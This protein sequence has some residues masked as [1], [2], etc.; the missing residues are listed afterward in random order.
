MEEIVL[1]T[2]GNGSKLDHYSVVA[3]M[4]AAVSQDHAQLRLLIYE[5][6][7]TRLRK[8]LYKQF[9][10]L[11]WSGI[12]AQVLALEA[13]I[14]Q[15]EADCENNLL[16]P[17]LVP[18]VLSDERHSIHSALVPR[19]DLRPTLLFAD[20]DHRDPPRFLTS[21][22]YSV[23]P[24]LSLSNETELSDRSVM[25]RR[26]QKS[27]WTFS[28]II[29]LVVAVVLGVAIYGVL[30]SRFPLGLWGFD[31]SV[32]KSEANATHQGASVGG[33][34]ATASSADASHLASPGIPIPSAYGVYAVSNKQLTELDL[35]PIKVPDQR[36]AISTLI[37]T[38]SLAHLPIG[39]LQFVVFRRDLANDAP[40]H[41][42]IRVVAQVE[43][44]LTFDSA[45]K[46][47]V[48]NVEDAWVVRSNSYQMRVAPM[49]DNPEMIV[50]RPEHAEFLF[51]AG[52]YALVLKNVA[53]DFTLDGP[54][55]DTSHCLERTDTL[56]APIYT[57]CRSP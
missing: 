48:T 10:Q 42:A 7:R 57:E 6:A 44:A 34:S 43:R 27:L 21:S 33:T 22:T 36:V 54:I 24:A 47:T 15:V 5:F 20:D 25:E 16:L 11:G 53:Y 50:I 12:A 51:P 29:Q 32:S 40:D 45:G 18:E 17:S 2:T 3:Q 26:G 28:W 35:L 1:R 38:P 49:P 31:K 39:Q 8:D 4:V 55:T 46:A 52:R 9:E 14:D 30:D 19:P 13:A 37:S 56:N 41:I 23:R